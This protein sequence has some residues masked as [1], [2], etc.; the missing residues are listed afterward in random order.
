MSYEREK[1]TSEVQRGLLEERL[2]KGK[3]IAELHY[4]KLTLQLQ[5]K[6]SRVRGEMDIRQEV[7]MNSHCLVHGA[8]KV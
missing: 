1:M 2:N 7:A 3:C 4:L 5:V 8:G 6:R